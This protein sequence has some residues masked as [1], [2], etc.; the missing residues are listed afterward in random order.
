MRS[1]LGGALT[2]E[3]LGGDATAGPFR[4]GDARGAVAWLA[5]G[6]EFGY[7]HAIEFAASGVRRGFHLHAGHQ[8][9]FY[10]FSGAIRLVA[11][12]A[13][14]TVDVTLQ[15]GDLAVFC[16]GVA[17][18]LVSESPAIAVAFGNGTDPVGDTVPVPDL[19]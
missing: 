15:A 4:A 16:P 13:D 10:V 7:L 1:Y 9:H 3:T 12:L 18:G 17:H 14:E 11:R 2:I 19:G 5:R 6:T 8:E